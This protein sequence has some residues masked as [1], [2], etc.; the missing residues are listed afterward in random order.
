MEKVQGEDQVQKNYYVYTVENG[1]AKQR[2]LNIRYI[3]HKSIAVN[4]GIAV[5]D[6]LVVLGQN[7]LRDGLPVLITTNEGTVL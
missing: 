3:N 4:S 5:G 2:K 7:N 6:T 1:H